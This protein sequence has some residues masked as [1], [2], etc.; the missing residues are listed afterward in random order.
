M[1]KYAQLCAHGRG[2]ATLKSIS[3]LLA[4]DQETYMPRGGGDARAEQMALLAGMMHDRTSSKDLGDLI[5]ACESESLDDQQRACVREFRRDY[6][7]QT[8]LPKSLV[9]EL[10]R[11]GSKAQDVWKDARKNNDF[12]AFAPWLSKMVDLS[13]QKATCYGFEPGGEVYDALLDEYE[14][15]AKARQV[16]SIFKPLGEQLSSLVR[17]LTESGKTPSDAP[18]KVHAPKDRQHALGMYVLRAIGFDLNAGRLD[19]TTHP[20]CEGLAPGDTRLTT[21]YDERYF[22]G[23]LYGT[24][25]EAGH[26]MYEQGLPKC[27]THKGPGG[28]AIESF[29]TPLADSISLGIH[30]SQSRMWENMVGRGRPFWKW[31]H[32]EACDQF[33]ELGKFDVDEI[34]RAVNIVRPSFIRVEADEGT[35]NLHVMLRFGIERAMIAGDLSIGDLP[36]AWNERFKQLLGLDVPDDAHGCLQDVHWSFGLFGYFPTYTLGNL[37]AAQFWETIRQRMPGLDAE[38][39]RGDFSQLLQWLNQNIHGHG[40]RYRAGELCEMVTRRPL[41][42]RPLLDY[43]SVK[44]RDVY[45]L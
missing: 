13:R 17:E 8:K 6:D 23:A 42:S 25:H 45:G 31:L 37:Y 36:G 3:A 34:Y 7:K 12:K 18:T 10:A 22:P 11:T 26:G 27:K 14:P 32:K 21:R 19:V 43:L 44:L 16:E 20:F 38:F 33:A 1:S 2:S 29:G 35:Y 4:W 9:E 39:T 5:A 30:E 15:N 24:M 41:E 40:R 28:D